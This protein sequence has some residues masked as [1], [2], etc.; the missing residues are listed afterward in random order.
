M[1]KKENMW[2][3]FF[4]KKKRE[5]KKVGKKYISMYPIEAE[6]KV[7][8]TIRINAAKKFPEIL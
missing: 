6:L 5:S 1:K 8:K 2:N 7:R 3:L 4:C